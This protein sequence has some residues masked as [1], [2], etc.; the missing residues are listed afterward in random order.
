MTDFS[1]A[2]DWPPFSLM[3]ASKE[4]VYIQWL[5]TAVS[6]FS[7]F[8]QCAWLAVAPFLRVKKM[9][10]EPLLQQVFEKLVLVKRG[11]SSSI[12]VKQQSNS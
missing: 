6:E 2:D 3:P 1:K 4:V 5:W 7:C 12:Q 9:P 11:K 8:I 10:G